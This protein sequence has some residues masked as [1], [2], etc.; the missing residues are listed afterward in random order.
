[1]SDFVRGVGVVP[2]PVEGAVVVVVVVVVWLVGGFGVVSCACKPKQG[3]STSA[4]KVIRDCCR[5]VMY[6]A[7]SSALPILRMFP[8]VL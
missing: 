7:P 6:G 4:A 8:H 3:K 2:V 5:R 1:I